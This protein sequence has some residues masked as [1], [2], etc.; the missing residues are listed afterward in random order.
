MPLEFR[1]LVVVDPKR[2]QVR[3]AGYPV[4]GSTTRIVICQISAEALRMLGN[5]ANATEDEL[6][7]AFDVF[8]DDIFKIASQKFDDGDHRP[9]VRVADFPRSDA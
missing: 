1:G 2:Q 8:A 4:Q 7:A 9:T 5:L 3:F 6:L